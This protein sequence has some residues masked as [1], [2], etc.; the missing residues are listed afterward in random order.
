MRQGRFRTL[1]GS[2]DAELLGK[3]CAGSH[4]ARAG[5]GGVGRGAVGTRGVVRE[6]EWEGH[7]G[8][9]NK[10]VSS[11]VIGM[12]SYFNKETKVP[13]RKIETNLLRDP[14]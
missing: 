8:Y 3:G 14:S 13:R 9:L 11:F 4:S 7:R 12:C 2:G 6:S 5:L 10:A 1:D